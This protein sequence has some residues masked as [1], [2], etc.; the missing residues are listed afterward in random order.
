MTSQQQSNALKASPKQ[1]K[2]GI[3]FLLLA[4]GGLE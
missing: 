2:R 3:D 1:V 4:A